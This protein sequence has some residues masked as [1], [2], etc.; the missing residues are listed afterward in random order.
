VRTYDGYLSDFKTKKL[1]RAAREGTRHGFV[2]TGIYRRIHDPLP[3]LRVR[4]FLK[5]LREWECHGIADDNQRYFALYNTGKGQEYFKGTDKHPF[6]DVAQ[7]PVNTPAGAYQIVLDT[8]TAF[9]KPIF[10]IGPG[11]SPIHQDRIAIAIIEDYTRKDKPYKK[12]DI[13]SLIRTNRIAE[14]VTA[15]TGQWASLP[16]TKQSR[17]NEKTGE[18]YTVDDV[19][20]RHKKFLDEIIGK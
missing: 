16:G 10:G 11:F 6:E 17:K 13:L 12:G 8:Y 18:Y 7:R 9:T 20:A 4:A 14:A 19:V 5:V 2:V 15:L 3:D 1:P